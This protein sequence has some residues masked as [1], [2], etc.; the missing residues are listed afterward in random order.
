MFLYCDIKFKCYYN[1]GPRYDRGYRISKAFCK[2]KLHLIYIY[3]YILHACWHTCMHACTY[4]HPTHMHRFNGHFSKFSCP[5][6]FL[7]KGFL[8][9]V[10]WTVCPSLH[11]L[12]E[13]HWASPFLHPLQLLKGNWFHPHL[14]AIRCHCPNIQY[15][16]YN[17]L[18]KMKK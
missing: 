14:S 5:L 18:H 15:T 4:T 1:S 13:T 11:Q 17:A 8:S 9:E 12:A 7:T 10:I 16:V 2:K 3:I 6:I